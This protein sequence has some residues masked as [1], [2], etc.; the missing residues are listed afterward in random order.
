MGRSCI[1]VSLRSNTGATSAHTS[2]TLCK[3]R[4]ALRHILSLRGVEPRA[5]KQM[6]AL[7]A[8]CTRATLRLN[9][10]DRKK[11]LVN[12]K[13]VESNCKKTMVDGETHNSRE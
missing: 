10:V 11:I 4:T 12:S 7:S 8:Y 5:L 1:L 6:I 9:A 2:G 13:C 3:A